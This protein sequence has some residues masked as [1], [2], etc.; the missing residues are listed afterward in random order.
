MKVLPT[1]EISY[2]D[3]T[4]LNIQ[5]LGSGVKVELSQDAISTVDS[6]SFDIQAA[7]I[8]ETLKV[9]IACLILS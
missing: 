7:L 1:N 4:V 9:A 5:P 8:S 3:R 2:I 6:P